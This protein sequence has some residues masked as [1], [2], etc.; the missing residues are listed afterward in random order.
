MDVK[1]K[2]IKI[3]AKKQVS[4]KFA[5]REFVLATEDKYPQQ[6]IMQVTQERCDLLDSFAEGDT[7]QA[8]INI[9]DIDTPKFT[10]YPN[11]CNDFFNIEKVD[12]EV[13]YFELIDSKGTI[14]KTIYSKDLNTQVKLTDVESGLYILKS[15][16]GNQNILIH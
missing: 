9:R 11:P 3:Y 2:L 7:I 8:F 13:Q 12:N 10:I 4:D 16:Q 15:I 14:V 6:I 5:L 1:G